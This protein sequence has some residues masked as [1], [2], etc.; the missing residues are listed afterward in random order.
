MLSD[1]L[2]GRRSAEAFSTAS[3]SLKTWSEMRPSSRRM[4]AQDSSSPRLPG[5]GS[6]PEAGAGG[7]ERRSLSRRRR[8]NSEARSSRSRRK[9][10]SSSRRLQKT[11]VTRSWPPSRHSA[12][13]VRSNCHIGVMP[14]PAA[15]ITACVATASRWRPPLPSRKRP[16]RKYTRSPNGPCISKRSAPGR[17]CANNGP[18]LPVGYTLTNNSKCCAASASE[19]GVYCR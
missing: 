4:L 10:T 16:P 3:A 19:T 6:A 8:A 17:N 11:S 1:A 15:T 2:G 5:Q 14:L 9:M 18:N 13:I 12:T 7:S